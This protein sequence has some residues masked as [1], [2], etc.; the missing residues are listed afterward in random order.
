VTHHRGAF[1]GSD[2]FIAFL[3]LDIRVRESG[4][5]K[6]RAKLSKQGEPEL[7][8]LL[9]WASHPARHHPRFDEYNRKQ[10]DKGLS[11]I[12]APGWPWPESWRESLLP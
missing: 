4:Y 1:S 9:Y 11:K 5:Y 7:R 2:A 8:R 6:G 3:G 12:A 10:L